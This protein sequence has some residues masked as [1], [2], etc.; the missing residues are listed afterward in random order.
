MIRWAKIFLIAVLIVSLLTLFGCAAGPNR[1][2]ERPAGF[3]A[4]LWHGFI[5]I[6]TFMI[7]LFTDT[8]QMYEKNN[9]GTWYDLGF[10]LGIFFWLGGFGGRKWKK[11]LKKKRE[12]EW[13]EIGDR[14]EEKVH[15]GIKSWLD[16]S[17][18][19]EWEEIGKKIEE[20]IK[21]EL[22]DWAES[23]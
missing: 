6:I 21:R 10:L 14:V 19:K 20:K 4:G 2:V 5:A 11:K 3:L 7:S 8:I 9:T 1:F 16:E 23:E 15:R 22:R 12:R 13:D 18:E 17:G